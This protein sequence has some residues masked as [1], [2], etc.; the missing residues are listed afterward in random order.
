MSSDEDVFVGFVDVVV[1]EDDVGAVDDEGHFCLLLSVI[2][3][4]SL[5][6]GCNL[7]DGVDSI[8]EI[9]SLVNHE[10]I[11]LY[12][13]YYKLILQCEIYSHF[14]LYYYFAYFTSL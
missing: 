5:E 11:K 14:F 12:K 3:L 4:S 8:T 10:T 2:F 13:I 7:V 9:Y 6:R 1:D